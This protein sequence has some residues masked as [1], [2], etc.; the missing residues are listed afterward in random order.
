MPG[1]S[2]ILP[3]IGTRQEVQHLGEM[4]CAHASASLTM[5]MELVLVTAFSLV[6]GGPEWAE[7]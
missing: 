4:A 2:D 3:G 1:V 6:P 5:V 7:L